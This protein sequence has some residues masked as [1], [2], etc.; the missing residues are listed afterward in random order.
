MIEKKFSTQTLQA[1][2]HLTCPTAKLTA[3]CYIEFGTCPGGFMLTV[4]E[5]DLMGAA[6]KA[7]DINI[8]R[9]HEYAKMLYNA[10]MACLGSREKVK[11]W[12]ES[13]GLRGTQ[14]SER[15]DS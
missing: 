2:E 13:G 14:R 11:Y 15:A 9:L 1:V 3:A 10:P 7:D 8:R 6:C 5:N 4:F 12:M